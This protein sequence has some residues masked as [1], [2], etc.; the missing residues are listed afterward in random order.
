VACVAHFQ[1]A[2]VVEHLAVLA[3]WSAELRR[4]L[5]QLQFAENSRYNG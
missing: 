3:H 1:I 2:V 4:S 5:R